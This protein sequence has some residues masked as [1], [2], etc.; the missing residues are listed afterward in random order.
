MRSRKREE[1]RPDVPLEEK[2]RELYPMIIE[3]MPVRMGDDHVVKVSLK[4]APE[5]DLD[6]PLLLRAIADTAALYRISPYGASDNR[7]DW[8]WSR[9]ARVR[10]RQL[11]TTTKRVDI[12]W[13]PSL[14]QTEELKGDDDV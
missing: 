4:L 6:S 5:T 14:E 7:D 1:L 13:K 2:I 12:L 10:G 3:I 8:E 9:K 11:T